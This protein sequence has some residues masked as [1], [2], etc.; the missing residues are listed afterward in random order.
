MAH[1]INKSGGVVRG[2]KLSKLNNFFYYGFIRLG[3]GGEGGE[4]IY[5]TSLRRADWPILASAWAHS[6]SL[7]RRRALIR[8][9]AS[10]QPLVQCCNVHKKEDG[11]A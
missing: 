3:G 11:S 8:R 6:G 10:N 5:L 4:D 9:A 2:R 7:P 1:L